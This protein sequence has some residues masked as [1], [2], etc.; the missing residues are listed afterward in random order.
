MK[1]IIL[2]TFLL[3]IFGS[4][5]T[6]VENCPTYFQLP[7]K[8]S[9]AKETYQIGDTISIQSKFSKNVEALNIESDPLGTF[10]M[11]GV[12]WDMAFGGQILDTIGVV[13][14]NVQKTFDVIVNPE[15]DFTEFLFSSGASGYF[16]EPN[17]AN[18]TFNLE[19]KII[20][21]KEGVFFLSFGSTLDNSFQN[22]KGSCSRGGIYGIS[23]MNEGADNNIHL[24]AES[25]EEH[26]N[27]WILQKPEERFHRAGGY[28]F[29]VVE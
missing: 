13:S 22:F 11:E 3:F 20:P 21:K 23:I 9:P 28:A 1:N 27:T 26:Y 29:K 24:L 2:L 14:F 15:F 4:S 10:D 7:V 17:Y 16:G 12:L 19:F 6:K 25:P 5:C 18:D 8:L